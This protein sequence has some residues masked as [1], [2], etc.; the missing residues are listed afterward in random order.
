MVTTYCWGTTSIYTAVEDRKVNIPAQG[1]HLISLLL[2]TLITLSLSFK[3]VLTAKTMQH[4]CGN[5]LVLYKPL[6]ATLYKHIWFFWLPSQENNFCFPVDYLIKI[7]TRTSRCKVLYLQLSA[8]PT[9]LLDEAVFIQ[10][11]PLMFQCPLV[12]FWAVNIKIQK[13]IRLINSL[14]LITICKTAYSVALLQLLQGHLSTKSCTPP[15]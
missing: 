12:P 14:K 1:A 10:T 3:R 11:L 13:F 8:N 2:G 4:F 6:A 7:P 9:I 15:S 5:N